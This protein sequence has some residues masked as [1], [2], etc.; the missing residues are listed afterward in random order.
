[1]PGSTSFPPPVVRALRCPVC[2]EQVRDEG[3]R[4]ICGHGHSFDRARQGYVSMRTGST[5]PRNADTADMVAARERVHSS[6]LFDPIA[7]ALAAS[8]SRSI[9]SAPATDA[10]TII[11][12]LAGGTG[13]YLST[14][15]ERLPMAYGL[16]LDLSAFA[17]RRAARSHPRAA[18]VGADLRDAFPIATAS[19]TAALSVFGPRNADEISRI[20]QPSGI[21]AVATPTIRHLRELI[22]PLSMLQVDENKDERVHRQLAAFTPF[23]TQLV[24]YS[25]DI[26][27]ALAG[28]IAGMGPS[29]HHTTAD[30]LAQR[31]VE[32]PEHTRVTVSV[33]ITLY[34]KV[35]P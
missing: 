13:Y 21:L 16:C 2:T 19:V 22:G 23:D 9:G 4:L 17:L 18:A 15:L 10:P 25:Q 31:T 26:T 3:R 27:P 30:D 29:A 20:L 34:R 7:L 32:L 11:A 33:S 6:G 5:S 12:D 24:E 8:V 1:M 28:D 14:V 35:Q